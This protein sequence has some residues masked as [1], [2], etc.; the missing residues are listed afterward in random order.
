M[1]KLRA[2]QWLRQRWLGTALAAL[3]VTLAKTP[4]CFAAP[5]P[6]TPGSGQRTAADCAAAPPAG[7]P[8][9]GNAETSDSSGRAVVT[10]VVAGVGV[11]GLTTGIVYELLARSNN[12]EAGKLCRA[13]SDGTS[14]ASVA[15][16]DRHR[17]LV[18][19]GDRDHRIGVVA[20]SVGGAALVTTAVL[21][22]TGAAQARPD[23][24]PELSLGLVDG[25]WGATL[26][27]RF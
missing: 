7:A 12:H 9:Q 19:A 13:G 21:L 27:G 16:L 24:A 3:L 15:E 5:V 2:E 22:V 10:L 26:G 11:A 4:A 18:S 20:L 8:P 14:C 25:H 6:A 23:D 17:Q 1:S